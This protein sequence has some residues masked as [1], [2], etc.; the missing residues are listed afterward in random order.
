MRELDRL[1]EELNHSRPL[2]HGE[3]E[4]LSEQF[5]ISFTN[6]S[7]AIE[8]NTLTLSETALVLKEGIT[9]AEKPLREHLE[10]L[11]HRDAFYYVQDLISR[12]DSALSETI[13][14]QIHSLV[15]MDD[16][17][18]RGVYRSLPVVISGAVHTPPQPYEV[19]WQMEQLMRDYHEGD[20]AQLHPVER[21]A[22]FHLRFEGIHP[23]IDGNGRTGR[24]L[25][26][27]EL[28]RAGF[29]PINVKFADRRRYYT[30]FT[31]YFESAGNPEAMTVLIANYT[32]QALK[33]RL[34]LV[35]SREQ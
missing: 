23:F 14:K 25:L 10:V 26:N 18:N 6:D 32:E 7:T 33:A 5:M 17:E 34:Q 20:M 35:E 2:N 3:I 1:L 22:L 21:A 8:G 30:C 29:P 4:R 9:I 11:G 16:A 31:D 19:P 28:M 12:E 15:L 24:L 27:L 13:I